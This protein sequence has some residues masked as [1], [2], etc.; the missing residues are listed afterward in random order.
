MKVYPPD[1]LSK[2]KNPNPF[3]LDLYPNMQIAKLGEKR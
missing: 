2:R 3:N 1:Y